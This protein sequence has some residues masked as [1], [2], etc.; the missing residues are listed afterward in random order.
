MPAEGALGRLPAGAAATTASASP[1]CAGGYPSRDVCWKT[2]PRNWRGPQRFS[3]RSLPP[4]RL[5]LP[6]AGEAI[7]RYLPYL[8]TSPPWG[9]AIPKPSL[10]HLIRPVEEGLGNRQ[11][12]GLRC[13]QVDDQL[14]L[15]GLLHGE[16]PRLGTL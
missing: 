6:P 10:D 15:R 4:L 7:E 12:E 3:Y 1:C 8:A 16:I 2:G 14:E 13:L 5:G 9:I 11:P